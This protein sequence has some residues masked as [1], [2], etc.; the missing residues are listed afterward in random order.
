MHSRLFNRVA[1]FAVAIAVVAAFCLPATA[2]AAARPEPGARRQRSGFSLFAEVFTLFLVNKVAC[3]IN[4]LGEVC[5]DPGN[6]PIGGGGFWPRGTPDQYIFNSGLQIAG[7]IPSDAGFSWAGDTVGAFFMDPRGTQQQGD[8]VTPVF[9]SLDPVDAQDWPNGGFVRDT[10]IYADVL[11]GRSN[12]SQQDLWVRSWDGNPNLLSG[13]THPMGVLVEMRGMAWNFPTGNE[14]ILYFVYTFYNVTASDPAAYAGLDPAI[15]GEVAAIGAQFQQGVQNTLD[16][17]IPAGGYTISNMFAAFFMDPDVEDASHNYSTAVLPFSLAAAYKHDWQAPTWVFPPDVFSAPVFAAAPGFVGVKYLKSPVNPANGLEYGLTLFSN[18]RNA[19]TGFPD[20]V[21]VIQMWR[22][23]S[24]N[25]NPAA[26]DNPCTVT[27]PI[28]SHLCYLDQVDTDTRFYQSSGPL[29]LAP[30]ESQTIV[31]AYVHAAP[32]ASAISI[33]TNTRPGIPPSGDSLALLTDTLRVIDRAV[34]WVSHADSL[35]CSDVVL[36]CIPGTDGLITQEEVTTVPRSLLQKS[37]VAQAVFDNKFLLPFAPE[38]P[39]F[40]LVPGNDQVTVVWQPSPT[41]TVGDPFFA[42]ANDAG[43]PLFDP[44]FREF[45]VEGYRVYR[46]RTAGALSL[47]AQ[48]DY[49]GTSFVDFTGAIDYGDCAPELGITGD[50]PV[51]FDFPISKTGETNPVDISDLVIQVPRGGRVELADGSVFVIKADTA[52]IGGNSGRPGL[53]NSGVPFAYVDRGVRNSLTYFYAVTAFDV[54]SVAS[55]PTSLESAP[56]ARAVTPRAPAS[57]AQAAVLVRS[58]TG[59]DDQPLN[60]DAEWPTI[61]TA[62]GTFSGN[63]PPTNSGAFDF[64]GAVLEALP[65]GDIE[66]RIDSLNGGFQGGFGTSPDLFVTMSAGGNTVLASQS[67]SHPSFSAAAAAEY[68]LSAPLVPYD[69]ALSLR[70]GLT[71]TDSTVRMP[72]KFTGSAVPFAHSSPG[73]GTASGRYGVAGYGT[74]RYLAHSRWFDEGG[75]EPPDPTIAAYADS[76]KHAGT[77]TGVGRIYS[78]SAYRQDLADVSAFLRGF[79]AAGSTA[80]YPADFVVTWAAGGAVTVRDVT[81]NI[82]L[83]FSG[84]T[85]ASGYSFFNISDILA[86][87]ITQGTF[88]AEFDLTGS[89]AFDIINYQHLFMIEPTCTGYWGVVNFPCAVTSETAELSPLDFNNDGTTDGQGIV[90]VVNGEPFF[91]EMNALPAAG[92]QWHL[93]AISGVM[94]ADCTPALGIAMTDCTNYT[95]EPNPVRPTSVPGLKYKITVEQQ[96]AVNPDAEANLDSVHTVPDPYYVTNAME[97]TANRKV[98]KWV[99]L[100][101]RV[102][103]RIYSLSGVLINIIEHNDQTGGGE[104]AWNLRNRNNQFVASGVYFYH[105]ETPNGQERVGRFTVVNFA[106]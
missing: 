85:T 64:L 19:A 103:I 98:L 56:I 60:L 29:T 84:G 102:I 96:F 16:V 1:R 97:I 89:G 69:S 27:D 28:G 13:R 52:V 82:S 8:G 54:N 24:G 23:L 33:G 61:D 42:I 91:M 105:L 41:E 80:W 22:Y 90:M 101:A 34:G 11:L 104:V 77:L 51:A 9:N 46:G 49:A 55:G 37:M 35:D 15:S 38:P 12:V 39:T 58:V 5:V 6:S 99:N 17:D 93:R 76:A 71:F 95:F 67:T 50:C 75:S 18:T 87:G 83:P 36:G 65:P 25:I 32:V 14:D 59:D 31:V 47:I 100:P 68:E 7:I 94:T 2:A 20:P 72:V 53:V 57:N 40:F 78:P 45:D 106:Q 43:S 10:A 74:S 73:V 81:H 86:T 62:T 92:T 44:N 63:I 4:N 70:M 21:G 79:N 88:G 66:L 30:G 26:G 3:G 48:F